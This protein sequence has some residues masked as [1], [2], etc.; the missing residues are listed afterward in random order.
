M[1]AYAIVRHRP[2]RRIIRDILTKVVNECGHTDGFEGCDACDDP[3]DWCRV[4][5][6]ILEKLPD[7]GYDVTTELSRYL[8]DA[9]P[10]PRLLTIRDILESLDLSQR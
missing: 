4:F 9:G 6:Q 8:M 7:R 1:V 10:C 5:T 3:C 2:D